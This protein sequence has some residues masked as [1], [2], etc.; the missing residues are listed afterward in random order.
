LAKVLALN[1]AMRPVCQACDQRPCAVNYIREGV[2]HY[3]SRCETCQRKGRG[4]KKRLARWEAAGYKKK[5]QCD[6][7]G[8]KARYS[9]QIL[10]YHVDG[11]LNNVNIKNL[12]SICK[13]C[14]EE[15][16]RSDLPWRP[17]DLAP[18]A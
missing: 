10:V 16:S 14:V 18:D 5:M 7:C 2:T 11:D 6:R 3:R 13:N 4:K 9:A 8:F 15:V 17:G 12:K 1:I